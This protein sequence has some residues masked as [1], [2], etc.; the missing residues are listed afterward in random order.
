MS[1]GNA[2]PLALVSAIAPKP[3]PYWLEQ[4]E[5]VAALYPAFEVPLMH[6]WKRVVKA[7]KT[8]GIRAANQRLDAIIKQ[9]KF[10][11]FRVDQS[12]NDELVN[13]YAKAQAEKCITELRAWML[14]NGR[15]PESAVNVV[16]VLAYH[17]LDTKPVEEL[18]L[19]S[20]MSAQCNQL[21]AE[22]T[23]AEN[24]LIKWL[25]RVETMRWSHRVAALKTRK[26]ELAMAS[27]RRKLERMESKLADIPAKC[28]ALLMRLQDQAWWRRKTRSVSARRIEGITRDLGFVNKA[29]SIY[30]SDFGRREYRRRKQ[31]NLEMMDYTVLENDDGE[32]FTLADLAAV[33]NANPSIRKTELMVRLAGFDIWAQELGYE[34]YAITLTTPSKYHAHNQRGF[35]GSY[36]N[37]N[38]KGYTARQAQDYLC[39]VWNKFRA[40]ACRHDWRYFGFRVA[41]PHHDGTPHWHLAL[42]IHPDDAQDLLNAF[43]AQAMKVDGNE[44][45][46]VEHRFVVE[47]MKTGINPKT[48]KSYSLAGYMAKYISKNVDGEH[49]DA[50]EYGTPA[51]SSAE[52]VV[53]WASRNG[54]RQFQQVG[55]PKVSGWRELRRLARQPADEIAQLPPLVRTAVEEVERLTQESAAEAWAWY[56]RYCAENGKIS[57]WRIVKT[58]EEA[59]TAIEEQVDETSGEIITHEYNYTDTKFIQNAYGE[60]VEREHGIHAILAGSEMFI[61]TRFKT[62]VRIPNATRSEAEAIRERRKAERAARAAKAEAQRA[63]RA[64]VKG[65]TAPPW[66]GVNNCSGPPVPVETDQKRATT[67]RGQQAELFH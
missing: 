35:K 46:A 67:K 44:R 39:D 53:V 38:F 52:S 16:P 5:G 4:A 25:N 48:G 18:D 64:A 63:A 33:S 26:M 9:F 45:G 65:A 21:A 2:N 24:I 27:Q 49:I 62:W 55:G 51:E 34:G 23:A 57:L 13:D 7:A 6:D 30:C 42:H 58:A 60:L 19:I 12:D 28:R 10:G 41:E 17:G 1:D 22:I 32:Q 14:G 59:M 66:T 8:G 29:R 47:K 54:I 56:C 40:K 3:K 11:D 61:Q 50:D 20:D 43:Y 15:M 36:R 37:P 31:A